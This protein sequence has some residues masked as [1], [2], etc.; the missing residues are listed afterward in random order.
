MTRLVCFRA[1]L[2]VACLMIAG[3]G[4][5]LPTYELRSPEETLR[6]VSEGM[7]AAQTISGAGTLTVRDPE[8]GN[9]S[10]EAALVARRPDQ[11]RVRAWKFGRS[12]ADVTLDGD[13]VL[14]ETDPR[15]DRDVLVEGLR[16]LRRALLE[17]D[18]EF[19][20][21]AEVLPETSDEML[22]ARG[23]LSTGEVLFARIDRPTLTLRS[24]S[25]DPDVHDD[26]ASFSLQKYEEVGGVAWPMRIRARRGDREAAFRFDWVELN[27]PVQ[28]GALPEASGAQR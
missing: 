12:V 1:A 9:V 2:L 14:G 4:T 22:I 23:R 17:I 19:Y 24:L 3:C 7:H 28:R 5:S 10:L 6:H 13:R 21:R 8:R 20:D 15:V 11:M 26:D 16:G 25:V 27:T 18:Q